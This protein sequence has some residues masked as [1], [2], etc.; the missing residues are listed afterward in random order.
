MFQSTVVDSLSF[1]NPIKTKF[2]F[3][4]LRKHGQRQTEITETSSVFIF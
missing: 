1:A 2:G 4:S 3:L